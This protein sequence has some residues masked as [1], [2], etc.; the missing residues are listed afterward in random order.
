[1]LMLK[2]FLKVE[3]IAT[4]FKE[5]GSSYIR[6]YSK[7]IPCASLLLNAAVMGQRPAVTTSSE[8][9]AEDHNRQGCSLR[10]LF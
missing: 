8:N 6:W 9:P 1:M 7:I 3:V 10:L 5:L 2:H 4:T